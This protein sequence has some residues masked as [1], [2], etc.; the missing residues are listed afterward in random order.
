MICNIPHP[1]SAYS[2]IKTNIFCQ[3]RQVLKGITAETDEV[4]DISPKF[5]RVNEVFLASPKITF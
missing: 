3:L 1:I 4:S 2:Q 5:Q